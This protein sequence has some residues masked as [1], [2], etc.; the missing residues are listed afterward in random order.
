MFVGLNGTPQLVKGSELLRL[1]AGAE[2]ASTAAELSV[3]PPAMAEATRFAQQ[4]LRECVTRRDPP[5]RG[6]AGLS[7]WLCSRIA[8]PAAG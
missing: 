7:L 1:A 6:G 4:V 8:R 5:A 2:V 3:P